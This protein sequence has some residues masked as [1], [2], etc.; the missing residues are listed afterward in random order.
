M[1]RRF[2]LGALGG[3]TLA[4]L[5]GCAPAPAAPKPDAPAAHSAGSSAAA[6]ETPAAA[7]GACDKPAAHPIPAQRFDETAQ[8]LAHATGCFIETDLSRTAAVPVN[9]VTGAMSIRQALE[10]ALAGTPLKI[11]AQTPDRITV[12]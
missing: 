4:L 7:K 2:A 8:Q 1:I 6:P 10:T 9:A 12:R 3:A 11:V 5:C